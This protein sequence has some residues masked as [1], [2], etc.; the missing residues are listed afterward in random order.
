[1]ENNNEFIEPV[2]GKDVYELDDKD[3]EEISDNVYHMVFEFTLSSNQKEYHVEFNDKKGYDVYDDKNRLVCILPISE[4][5]EI[6][7]M[8]ASES[9]HSI[10][11]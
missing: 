9:K 5:S 11:D 3:Y 2:K 6:E 7:E 10:S 8:L 4:A 1:M